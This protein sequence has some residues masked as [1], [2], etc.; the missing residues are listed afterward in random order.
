MMCFVGQLIV[1][2]EAEGLL[3]ELLGVDINAKQIE[4][5]CHYIGGEIEKEGKKMID[6]Q[7]FHKLQC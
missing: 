7:V 1:F 4:R 6:T 5:A 2:D 3:R